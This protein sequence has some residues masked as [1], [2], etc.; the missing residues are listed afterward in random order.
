MAPEI[1]FDQVDISRALRDQVEIDSYDF[2]RI[3]VQIAQ[4][5]GINIPDSKLIQMTNL[6]Q[7]VKY[8]TEHLAGPHQI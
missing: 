6:D 5:T 4:Q 1:V 3:V 2:Y 7:L 8:I